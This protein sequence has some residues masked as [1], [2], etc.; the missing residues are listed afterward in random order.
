MAL[1][2]TQ[3]ATLATDIQ[4]HPELTQ[5]WQGQAN[6]NVAIR[7]YYNA[8]DATLAD[9]W[10]TSLP[11]Q[12]VSKGVVWTEFIAR[13]QGERDCFR[14][15][16]QFGTINPSDPNIQQG[17]IDC[18]SGPTGAVT[19]AN[20]IALSKRKMTRAERLFAT[21]NTGVFTMTFEGQVTSVEASA[22]MA[23]IPGA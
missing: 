20:L 17:I 8:A 15:M 10:R 2:T 21:L 13:S 14:M 11:A 3:I 1:T 9:C 16:I 19:R 22:A 12:D 5:F 18:F 7:D 6:D 4:T 23:L